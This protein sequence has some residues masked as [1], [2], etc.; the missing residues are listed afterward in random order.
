MNISRQAFHHS[1]PMNT[2]LDVKPDFKQRFVDDEHPTMYELTFFSNPY[3]SYCRLF[4]DEPPV[5]L[6][7]KD[8]TNHP[9]SHIS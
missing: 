3:Y 4:H 7:A 6:S 1:I 5:S 2:S 8:T 9:W